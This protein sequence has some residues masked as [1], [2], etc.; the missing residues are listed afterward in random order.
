MPKITFRDQQKF[1]RQVKAEVIRKMRRVFK[2]SEF[3]LDEQAEVLQRAFANSEEFQAL[4]GRLK[5]QFGFTDEEVA[6][7]DRVL[8][9]LV[10]GSHGVTVKKVKTSGT[11]FSIMLEWADYD[12]LKDHEFAQHAL[13]RLDAAGREIGVTDIIS[14]VQWLEEG[15]TIQGYQFFRP[16]AANAAFSRSG[17]GLMRPR[18]GGVFTLEPTRV[19]ERIGKL[20]NGSF[21]RK[22]FGV[23]LRREANR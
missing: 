6:Q 16:N 4:S 2:K 1:E 22:G 3:L 19:F 17:E 8:T 18:A 7:L 9:L 20:E 11:S 23:V 12:K 5:G 10:P 14:W 13:T 15:V 21:L